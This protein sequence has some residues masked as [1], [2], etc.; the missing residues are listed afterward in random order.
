MS[1]QP[2]RKAKP[3]PAAPLFH[4]QSYSKD[5]SKHMRGENPIDDAM[6]ALL[7]LKAAGVSDDDAKQ[8]TRIALAGFW[9]GER[10]YFERRAGEGRPERNAAIRRDFQRGESIALLCRRYQLSRVTVWRILGMD[11]AGVPA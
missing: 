5:A 11:E 7:E 6:S 2:T 4:G 1:I 10:W 3:Q 8:A 9:G